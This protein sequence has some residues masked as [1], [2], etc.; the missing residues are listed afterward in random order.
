VLADYAALADQPDPEFAV[1]L[2]KEAGVATVPASSF[3]RAPDPGRRPELR[4]V[5]FAFCKTEDVLRQAAERLERF[6]YSRR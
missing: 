5:R 1:R 4:M 6:A 2:V 3:F